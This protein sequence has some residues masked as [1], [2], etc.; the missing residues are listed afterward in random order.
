MDSVDFFRMLEASTRSTI[1]S[2][3]FF[4]MAGASGACSIIDM[5]DFFRMPGAC[6]RMADTELF[7]LPSLPLRED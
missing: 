4:R 6:C 3:D 2:V 7:R 1:D 5:V